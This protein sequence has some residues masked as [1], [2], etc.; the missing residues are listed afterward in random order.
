VRLAALDRRASFALLG[1]G[2][3]GRPF[4]LLSEL[5]PAA[6]AEA[7]LVVA[8]FEGDR[9]CWA[10]FEAAQIAHCAPELGDEPLPPAQVVLAHGDYGA[11]V[12]QVREAI[13]RG[14]V[15]QVCLTLRARIGGVNGAELFAA[16]C[17]RGPP[18]FAAWVRLPDGRELVSASPELFFE[19]EG[20]RVRTEP[21]KGTAPRDGGGTLTASTKDQA[22]LAMITDLLRNDL[23]QVCVPKTVCVEHE[24]R[25]LELPYAV[26]TVS[27]VAGLLPPGATPLDVLATLHPGGSVT[28]APKRA[29]TAMIRALEEGPRGLYTGALGLWA[30]ERATFSLLIRTASRDA[31][32]FVYG[33]GSGVVY[34]STPDAEL[35]EIR[36]KLE[37]L[38]WPLRSSP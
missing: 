10:T 26:Q 9:A 2:F 13:A 21:M 35:A 37:A 33:V 23:A 19:V 31:E 6:R 34:D 8:P 27:D 11:K 17:R 28:G 4:L 36:T 3:G 30:G 15:Y 38:P 5:S 18:R 14:D 1:P 25:L 22:E 12:E 24:R 29:A 7:L 32:G 20:Q 16:M